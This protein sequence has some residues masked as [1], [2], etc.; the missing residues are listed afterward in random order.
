MGDA[1]A[2]AT[3]R[4][5]LAVGESARRPGRIVLRLSDGE[6]LVVSMGVLADT[7]LP[8][9]GQPLAGD[10]LE[11]WRR[12]SR[13]TALVDRALAALARGR[14]S[15]RE[16]ALRL[17]RVEPDAALVAAALERVDA[18]GVLSDEGMA[19]AEAAARLRRGEGPR[20]VR[21]RLRQRGIEGPLA[22]AAVAGAIADAAFD[23]GGACRALARRR[24]PALARLD[25]EV[26]RRRL[27][28]FLTRRGFSGG[29]VAA[30]LRELFPR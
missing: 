29:T 14:R 6:R 24:A 4:T 22:D 17:R 2:S 19:S 25:P 1:P 11:A 18:A 8:V 12:D 27:A 5:V 10:R 15:R 21:Q 9:V 3:E 23:E 7:G 30:V 26:A 13:I 28:G 16:L 20:R